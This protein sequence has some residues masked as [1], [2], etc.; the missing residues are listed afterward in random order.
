MRRT[1]SC[2]RLTWNDTY[3]PD[4]EETILIRAA[5]L[6]GRLRTR[7]AIANAVADELFARDC[8]TTSSL[9]GFGIFRHWYVDEVRR[10][11]IQLEGTAIF[12]EP[13]P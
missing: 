9:D 13:G 5:M 2:E 10:L 12:T 6:E 4:R 7:E 1:K 11:L 3:T 8:R